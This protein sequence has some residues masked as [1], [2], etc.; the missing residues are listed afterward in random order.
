MVHAGHLS[1]LP[2]DQ[3]TAGLSA[4]LDDPRDH[5][6]GD[7]H[8]ELARGVVVQKEQRL[9]A[10]YGDIV[11]AHADEVDADG[12][13]SAGIDREPQ[14]GTDAVRAGDEDRTPPASFG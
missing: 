6:F 12:V 13:V 10:L 8:I 7:R 1:R 5:A 9:G 2:A 3:G 4:S 14:L 11:D